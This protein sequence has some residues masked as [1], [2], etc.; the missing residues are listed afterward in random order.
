MDIRVLRYFLAT[1][2][3]QNITR[4]AETL[5]IAQPS[6][7][8]QLMELEA[9]LGKQLLIRGKRRI[10]LTADGILLRKRAEEIVALLEKTEQ[11]IAST[12]QDI[13]GTVAI[14]GTPRQCVLEA[15][16]AL[17]QQYS[18]IRFSFHVGDAPDITE[19]LDHGSLDFIVLLDRPNRA[20]YDAHP[21][22]DASYWGLL[23]KN[24]DPLIQKTAITPKDLCS[25]PLVIAQR[26]GIRQ[27]LFDWAQSYADQLDIIATYNVLNGT[28]VPFTLYTPGLV[29]TIRD[30]LSPTID[31]D[32]AF[33][34][35]DPPINTSHYLVWKRY[36]AFSP[37]SQKYLETVYR[38]Y[39][40]K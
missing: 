22:P 35:L 24:D 7:S 34:P 40:K 15:A 36:P 6:L 23:M 19:R 31:P 32:V 2:R 20:T 16:S 11:E 25:R 33:R 13:S 4:A 17:H 27:M 39:P 1:A 28:P 26:E 21:L 3:E 10:T 12:D 9:E 29:L 38:L 5:H 14:G 30:L 8:K 18:K 37:A